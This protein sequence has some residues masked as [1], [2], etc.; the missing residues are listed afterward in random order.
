[1]INNASLQA[2]AAARINQHFIRPRY[3]AFGFASLPQTLRRLLLDEPHE[4]VSFGS[5]H[6]LYDRYDTVILFF[7]D[8]F[9]WRFFQQWADRH[10]FLER[11]IREGVVT[12]LTSQFPST[13]AAHVTTIHTGLPVGQSG[14]YEWFFYEPTLD[15]IIAP[16]LFSFAGDHERD[17][18]RRIGAS[19][20][21]LYPQ[22]TLYQ[23]FA[24]GGVG[25]WVF[26]PL[27][28]AHSPYSQTVTNGATMIA[29]RT[30]PEAITNLTHLLAHQRDRAYYFLYVDSIDT[31]C[32]WYGP[33]SPQVA[34]EIGTF[35]DMLERVL[36]PA[37][38]HTQNR[39]LLLLTADHGQTALDPHT[40]IYLNHTLPEL[41]PWIKT[42]SAGQP[43]VPAGSSRDL[44]LHIKD[45]YRD[46]AH[47]ALQAH[48]AG[49][50]DVRRVPDLVEQ[51]FFGPLP[52][53]ATFSG[54]IGDL[55]VLPYANEAVWW[56][57]QGRFDQPFR[58]QHGGLSSDE[59]ETLLLV[60]P[61][62][63]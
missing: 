7:V 51:G 16:L 57:E 19:P 61:F 44:F 50:A 17:T 56:Y 14:M 32:H 6:D 15:T 24:A 1:M 12:K 20:T 46:E 54:R 4:G 39:T 5:R 3:D 18:L 43:L 53:S 55:V 48:L 59:M 11:I 37:L 42:N 34:A 45:T 33:Q 63:L 10:P 21:V 47:A 27:S 40:T 25:S 52:V 2:V 49:K 28:Y 22:R 36:Y 29:Y 60:Q 35:W 62:G 30:L 26:Q 58:G 23:E 38:A 31:I 41:Q 13:T 9:G 8:A